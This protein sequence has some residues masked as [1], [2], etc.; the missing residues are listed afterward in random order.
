MINARIAEKNIIKSKLKNNKKKKRKKLVIN[1]CM[2]FKINIWKK[3]SAARQHT[4]N[5]KNNT[6]K[7]LHISVSS[8]YRVLR[9]KNLFLCFP[10]RKTI[11][12]M[13]TQA[14]IHTRP[15]VRRWERKKLPSSLFFKIGLTYDDETTHSYRASYVFHVLFV[16]LRLRLR[17]SHMIVISAVGISCTQATTR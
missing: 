16:E 4:S 13:R 8:L 7:A 17:H 11:F 15:P 12:A 10:L 1:M 2:L 9:Q 14:H 3:K 6:L 5:K